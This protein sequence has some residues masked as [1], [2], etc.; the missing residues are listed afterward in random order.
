MKKHLLLCLVLLIAVG[1]FAQTITSF[2]PTSATPGTT[3]TIT[4]T[5]L[6]GT[7]AVSFG[8]VA[9]VAYKIVSSTSI[10]AVVPVTTSGDLAVTTIGGGTIN[11]GG[12]IYIPS[13]APAIVSA[14]MSGTL[15]SNI[16]VIG[17]NLRT[18]TAVS[19]GGVPALSFTPYSLDPD[20]AL[21]VTVGLGASGDISV[22]TPSGTSTLSGFTYQASTAPYVTS[23]SPSSG[24]P[25]TAITIDGY[26]MDGVTSVTV[27]SVPALSFNVVSPTRIM[28]VVGA[29]TNGTIVLGGSTGTSMPSYQFTLTAPP[30]PVI[31]FFSPA[32]AAPGTI[33][34]ITGSNFIG[35]KSVSFGGV[36]SPAY[37]VVS[38]TSVTAVV[39][40]TASGDISLTNGTG[41]TIAGG[42]TYIPSNL[43]TIVSLA[44]GMTGTLGSNVIIIGINLRN[45]TAV[46]FGGVPALSFIP[47][48][49]DPDRALSV[50]VGLGASGDVSVTT[51]AGTA[52]L[53]GFTYTPSTSPYITSIAPSSGP[54]GTVVTLT[55]YN[56][57]NVNSVQI[58]GVPVLS[59]TIVS[60][61]SITAVVGAGTSRNVSV[62][63]GSNQ[64]GS[65]SFNITTPAAPTITSFS[66]ASA[67]PGT[68][69]TITGTNLVST[70]GITF[71]G[72]AAAGYKVISAT[73]VT[74]VVP[75][76]TSGD[77]SLATTGGTATKGGFIYV[78]SNAPTI[79]SITNLRGTLGD[80]LY[81]I[82]V[83]LGNATA[84]SFGG[85]PAVAFS[86]YNPDPDHTVTAFVGS[87]ASGDIVVTTPF[88]TATLPGFVYTASTT[89]FVTAVSP[90]S[91][92]PGTVVTIS[93]YNFVNVSDVKIGTIPPQ[94]YT[95]VSP[96]TI[97]AVVGSGN[98]GGVSVNQSQNLYVPFTVT[99]APIPTIATISPASATPGTTVTITGTGFTGASAVKF[100]GV[101]ASSFTVVSSTSITA[102]VG[103]GSSGS[104]SITTAGG[105][106]TS[107]GFTYVAAP[108]ISSF[109]PA[110]AVAGNTITI[111]GGNFTGTS[112]VSFGGVAAASFTVASPTSIT[113]VLGNGATG[114]VS[115]TNTSGTA[116]KAGF[117]YVATPVI[118]ASGLTEIN[119]GSSVTLSVTAALNYTYQWFKDGVLIGIGGATNTYAATQTGVYTVMA[120]TGGLSIVSTPVS[121][122]ASLPLS[123]FTI[124]ATTAIC[125]GAANG[126][127]KVTGGVNLPYTVKIMGNNV[128]TATYSFTNSYTIPNL[129]A[130]TYSLYINVTGYTY[131]QYFSV[132]V[133]EPKD[134][135]VYSATNKNTNSIDLTLDGG[136]IYLI[137]V[138]NAS[139]TTTNTNITLPLNKGVNKISVTT[140]KPCQGLVEKRIVIGDNISAYPNPFENSL[141]ISLGDKTIASARVQI[142]NSSGKLVFNKQMANQ[143][144]EVPL[145]LTALEHT[146]VYIMKLTID[147]TEYVNKIIKK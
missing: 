131:E 73:S 96:T 90:S 81:I 99:A 49:L 46:S 88:G 50:S 35:T 47:Y 64:S 113:A 116:T 101:D 45:A 44:A 132:K 19:F 53:P 12:F 43:P 118:T 104:V 145:D 67:T 66:P 55:G 13:S 24:P 115:V 129:P 56:F 79:T 4:G 30:G 17:I 133:T 34:T 29:G 94:A 147:N 10:T 117:I 136:D 23:V 127:V 141:T 100:G 92:P 62:S 144:G 143:S 85:V 125:K 110:T 111:T 15:G 40:V 57:A 54:P 36:V 77:V 65:Y 98:N 112:A 121:V 31:T 91:G 138:N 107:A 139:Y 137:K 134:L 26:N 123:N 25:G 58:G 89:P 28:A 20:K 84:V 83:N 106:V 11:K 8:G 22:T 33:V 14:G 108:Y 97:T 93:G 5:D 95:V 103:A 109:S 6:A 1:G 119:I 63:D 128:S 21:S 76:T 69:V 122:H 140:D 9:A 37:K 48:G 59:Y 124:L 3:V 7:T 32:S 78:P 39:P 80:Y 86:N 105:T 130:G 82:G 146:Q 74:A 60:P 16:T 51:P 41:T 71:G 135:S 102:V 114:A 52:T 120:T 72:V 42:F 87:G 75:V 70:T 18:A 38:A 27:G 61:T 68:M 126:A 142:F 2:M